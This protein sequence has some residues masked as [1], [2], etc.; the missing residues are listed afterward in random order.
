MERRQALIQMGKSLGYVVA[1][2]SF[3]TVLEG[4]KT[5]ETSPWKPQFF[6]QEQGNILVA[7]IDSILPKT[8]TLSAS[9]VNVHVFL[10]KFAKEVMPKNEK[11]EFKTAITTI[12][13]MAMKNSQKENL[14]EVS[15]E[16]VTRVLRQAFGEEETVPY[17]NQIRNL[18]IWGYKCTEYVGEQLLA[19]DP[20]P[21][22]YI[23]CQDVN[24]LT[25]GKA[26]A[27]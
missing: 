26:W 21:G 9:E 17:L 12:G 7:V 18:T 4:C 22:Q 14:M 19:Y 20:I 27:L 3:I 16:D 25:E 15:L 2:P 10:D 1:V 6:T 24:E 11:E 13:N 8:T 5:S 23:V